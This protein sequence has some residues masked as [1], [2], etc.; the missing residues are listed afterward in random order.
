M[1]FPVHP[2]M[3]RHSTDF[4]LANKGIPMRTIQAYLDKSIK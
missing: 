1:S 2:H 3:L 4:C